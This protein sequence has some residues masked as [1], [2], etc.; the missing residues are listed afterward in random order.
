MWHLYV[1]QLKLCAKHACLALSSMTEITWGLRGFLQGCHLA[2]SIMEGNEQ[3]VYSAAWPWYDS[4]VSIDLLDLQIMCLRERTDT[5]DLRDLVTEQN[6]IGRLTTQ[7]GSA[8]SEALVFVDRLKALISWITLDPVLS[9]GKASPT[10]THYI[11]NS[12]TTS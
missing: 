3:E 11:P 8:V 12:S 5:R 6:S 9:S 2:F 7:R 1:S 10:F 4:K